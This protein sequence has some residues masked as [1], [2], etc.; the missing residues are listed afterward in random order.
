MPASADM[1]LFISKNM[2]QHIAIWKYRNQ[3]HQA[4]M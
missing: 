2:L 4:G 1:H 3:H